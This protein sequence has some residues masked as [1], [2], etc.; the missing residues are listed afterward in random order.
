MI[1]VGLTGSIGMGKSTTAS[2]FADAGAAVFDADQAVGALYGPGG[3]AVAPIA[4]RFPGCADPSFGVDRAKLSLVLQEDPSRFK[5]LEEIVHPLVG[6]ARLKF[7]EKAHAEG[8][9]I[10]VL[11]IPLLF[12]T[13]QADQVDYVVVVSAPEA[14]QRA[15]VLARPGMDD[16]KFEAILARQMPDSVKREKADFVIET[17]HGL[18]AA[19][20]QVEDVIAALME[21]AP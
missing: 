4:A 20:A 16:A 12:E 8:R 5:T 11:D 2:M 6:Q 21:P 13:G 1:T 14:L 17:E 7:F 9:K 19:R 18:D 15:R 3:A 10:V